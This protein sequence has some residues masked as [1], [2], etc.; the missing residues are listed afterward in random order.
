[1]AKFITKNPLD[2]S[3]HSFK[4]TE[5]AFV[6]RLENQEGYRVWIPILCNIIRKGYWS[7]VYTD[8]IDAKQKA[9]EWNIDC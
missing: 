9:Y 4:D 2:I 1:M 3:I 8:L 5:Y 7:R 6:V